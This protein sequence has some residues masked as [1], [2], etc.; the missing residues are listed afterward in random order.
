MSSLVPSSS[1]LPIIARRMRSVLHS[2]NRV[3]LTYC[4]GECFWTII[5]PCNKPSFLSIIYSGNTCAAKM[6]DKL[7]EG[8]PTCRVHVQMVLVLNIFLIDMIGFDS[9]R[10][11]SIYLFKK[12]RE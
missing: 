7:S 8:D 2:G 9:L 12:K 10:P 6:L 3:S 11:K 1:M 5:D 4:F